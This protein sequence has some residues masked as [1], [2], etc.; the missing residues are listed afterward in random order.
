MGL[1]MVFQD[2]GWM[3]SPPGSMWFILLISLTISIIS[4]VLTKLLID[5]KEMDRKQ[6]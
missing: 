4:V 5:T 2:S 1:L 3:N 6:G